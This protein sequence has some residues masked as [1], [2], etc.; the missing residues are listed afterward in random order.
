M[1][2]DFLQLLSDLWFDFAHSSSSKRYINFVFDQSAYFGLPEIDEIHFLQYE[3]VLNSLE[4]K[5]WIDC[6]QT[7]I[8]EIVFLE[9]SGSPSNQLINN[10]EACWRIEIQTVGGE[11]QV[12]V[13]LCIN[14]PQ[15]RFSE[16][17]LAKRLSRWS[18]RLGEKETKKNHYWL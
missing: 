13:T 4:Y 10:S 6:A 9:R 15:W 3:S 14:S 7:R 8:Y 5:L 12:G 17:V 16:G 1:C 2:R 11:G 18:E